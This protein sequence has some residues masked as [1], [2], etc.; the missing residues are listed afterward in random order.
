MAPDGTLAAIHEPTRINV[1]E[2]PS[3]SQFAELGTDAL[4]DGDVAWVGTPPR[5]LVLSR[6]D[7]YSV[8][9]LVDPF[10]PRSIAELRLDSPMR[11]YAAVGSHA[12]V[13]GATS[14][15][16]LAASDK[17][18]TPHVFPARAQPAAAG[19]AGTQFIV[20]TAST[21]EEWDP[22]TRM[23][24]RR[25][26][27]PRPASIT[28]VGGSDRVVWMTTQQEPARL[29]VIALVNRGQPKAHDLPEPIAA[30]ASHPRSDLVACIG[31]TTGRVWAV[32]LDGRSG[33][34]QLDPDG[35]DRA[36]AVGIV[37]GRV[38]G[39][40]AAQAERAI[41]VV[42]LE[43]GEAAG[44]AAPL[45]KRSSLFG[46]AAVA[47][48]A[49][50][51]PSA[52]P[53]PLEDSL[54]AAKPAPAPAASFAAA[55][56]ATADAPFASKPPK[57]PLPADAAIPPP[58]Y[59]RRSTDDTILPPTRPSA[60]DLR[61]PDTRRATGDAMAPL[62][63]PAASESRAGDGRRGADDT[64]LPAIAQPGARRDYLTAFRERVENP[65]ARTEE[66]IAGVPL[67]PDA[68][69]RWRDE[70]VSWWADGGVPPAQSPLETLA[71]RFDVSVQVTP[72]L[73]LLYVCHLRGEDGATPLEVARILGGRWDEALGRGEL[74]RRGLAT[75][76]GSRVRLVDV[77][78]RAL[79][80]LP[81][82]TGVLLGATGVV[83]LLGPCAIVAPGPLPIIAEACLPSI[84]GAILAAH[85]DADP[86]ELV[87]EAR[88]YG[89]V[90][91]WRVRADRLDHVPSDQPI[92]LVVDDELTAEMLGVPRLS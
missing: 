19:S 9:H 62:A 64:L 55:P 88:A 18:I 77:V 52:I 56:V 60:P 68:G 12:L 23:P 44:G 28:A 66:P 10:G 30:V 82:R 53:P 5:L 11:L 36:D 2:I 73:E 72:A 92:I 43:R 63:R 87:A 59:S 54:F 37:L 51:E 84:G 21:I 7:S 31:A 16:V 83:S 38:A 65:R 14:A 90:P 61:V 47:S 34:R 75:Y 22:A 57:P 80:E 20:A 71:M 41:A 32:D 78:L 89:A 46:R 39:V 48:D 6:Y 29:D 86:A 17:A 26:K 91:L 33:V 13:I 79:D 58:D 8:V 24:K 85:A 1:V 45:L 70:L 35:I 69:E 74:A 42:T 67:W 25:L 27:L 4:A 15:L 3:C 40:L 50:G 76:R 81:P 49:E